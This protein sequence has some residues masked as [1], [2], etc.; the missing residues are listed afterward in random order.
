MGNF[1]NEIA[2]ELEGGNPVM[3]VSILTA[4]GST[5][6]GAGAMMAVFRDG[7]S[8]GTIGGGN[9]E[10]ECQKLG[11]TLLDAGR[12]AIRA[13]RFTPG[14]AADLG[15]VCGGDVTVHFHC[16]CGGEP[17]LAGLF[18]RAGAAERNNEN[19]W[20]V[21]RLEGETVTRLLLVTPTSMAEGLPAELLGERAVWTQG[22]DSWFA[23]P[24]ARAGRV[25]IFGAGHVSAALEPLLER[26][27]FRTVIYD[28]RPEFADPKRFRGAEQVICGSFEALGERLTLGPDDYVVVMTRGHQ[29]DYEVLAQ[30]L[31]SGARYFGC[32]GSR[33]K[34]SLCRER[35]LAAGF[36]DGDYQR[37]HAPIGLDIGA[38]T[39]EE[40]AL[41]VAAELV[42]VRAGKLS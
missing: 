20:L 9:V 30:T 22:A 23:V 3:L 21:R 17:D 6:R 2:R 29:A 38:E 10:Y 12:S 18:R 4:A 8:C 31:R 33:R 37:L 26:L 34:L 16:L 11:H 39:P 15:M 28:D 32:I 41:S 42:A 14:Q 5:P 25:Y 36:T 7:R 19:A 40:I 27:G 24:V 35:L 13:F 1:F